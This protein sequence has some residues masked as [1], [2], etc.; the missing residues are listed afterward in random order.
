MSARIK[1][2]E[3][4]SAGPSVR[5]FSAASSAGVHE[6]ASRETLLETR[7]AELEAA[8]ATIETTLPAKLEDARGEGAREALAERSDAEAK[9]LEALRET[10]CA[11]RSD[12]TQRLASWDAAAAGISR[13]VLE[14][15][16]LGV[17]DRAEL[18]KSAIAARLQALEAA[19]VVRIR[20]SAEDF[21][22]PYKLTAIADL[23]GPAVELAGDAALKSGSCVVDLKLGHLDLGLGQQWSRVAALLD[24]LEGQGALP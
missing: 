9:G 1:F 16:F 8:L 10:L 19:S 4:G 21:P 3:V 7:I 15:V 22:E 23:V 17:E 18:V 5:A 11:C 12:W 6:T 14:R 24:Q 2:S 13:A 20:V